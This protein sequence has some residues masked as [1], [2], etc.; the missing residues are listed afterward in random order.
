M[1]YLNS[2]LCE[3]ITQLFV[4]L[5]VSKNSKALHCICSAG[6]ALIVIISFVLFRRTLY[7]KNSHDTSEL[8]I[9]L[10]CIQKS[11]EIR[12]TKFVI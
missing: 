5:Q 10:I 7:I 1:G 8:E 4:I 6:I 12:Y 3:K 2:S 9:Y 11:K